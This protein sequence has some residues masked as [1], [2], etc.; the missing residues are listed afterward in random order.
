[1]RL[2]FII[3]AIVLNGSIIAQD[4]L[5]MSSK[6]FINN[7]NENEN[8][9]TKNIISNKRNAVYNFQDSLTIIAPD[10]KQK[11]QSNLTSSKKSN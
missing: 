1:M 11:K 6:R 4:S 7:K 10:K 2:L 8:I 5:L 3:I 9:D